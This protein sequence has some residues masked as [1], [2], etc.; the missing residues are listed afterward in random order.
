MHVFLY[1]L[2][3]YEHI[4]KYNILRKIFTVIASLENRLF[5]IHILT[6][7]DARVNSEHL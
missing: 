6:H 2:Y 5:K 7:I 3:I 1:V 4:Y